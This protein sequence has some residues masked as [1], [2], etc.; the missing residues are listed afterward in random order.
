MIDYK[1][2]YLKYKKKYQKAGAHGMSPP[3]PT[4]NI[5]PPR[6]IS[7]VQNMTET[8]PQQHF[9]RNNNTINI[10]GGCSFKQ[11]KFGNRL[12]TLIGENHDSDFIQNETQL[13]KLN[14]S[15]ISVTDY[16]LIVLDSN[17]NAKVV[18]EN[19]VYAPFMHKINKRSNALTQIPLFLNGKDMCNRS[20]NIDWRC[21]FISSNFIQKIYHSILKN[22]DD[23]YIHPDE[24][25]LYTVPDNFKNFIDKQIEN[26]VPSLCSVLQR[27]CESD[28][29]TEGILS[30]TS[31]KLLNELEKEIHLCNNE[32]KEEF[33]KYTN[34]YE[35]DELT[36][37][38]IK[39][40][41]IIMK[42]CLNYILDYFC[43]RELLLENEYDEII[44][45]TGDAH[46][47]MISTF[48]EAHKDVENLISIEIECT[49]HKDS[50]Q[51]I[52]LNNTY[53]K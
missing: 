48:L 21:Y 46:T 33:K 52:S 1:Y 13:N 44:T 19:D 7:R 3:I 47:V 11:Y 25:K 5:S 14:S 29:I 4:R 6:Y 22:D 38:F 9:K 45:V 8:I 17:E 28:K 34:L 43:L 18:L 15:D 37:T 20:T 42:E 16:V 40:M 10:C 12:I 24:L 36:D 26:P 50:T 31:I 23:T 2:K 39:D 49:L 51:C 41:Q 32:I 35:K 53:Y 27:G 30:S